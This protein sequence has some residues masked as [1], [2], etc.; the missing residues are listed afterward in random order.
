MRSAMEV[1]RAIHRVSPLWN[2]GADC[3]EMIFNV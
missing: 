3:L 2:Y 1:G